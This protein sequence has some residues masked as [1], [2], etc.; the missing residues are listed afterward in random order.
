MN[1]KDPMFEEYRTYKESKYGKDGC[2]GVPK[3]MLLWGTFHGNE[4]ALHSAV[5]VS[6]I[7]L[8]TCATSFAYSL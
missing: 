4:A 6:S 5:A 7:C 2:K 8:C 1:V 3:S